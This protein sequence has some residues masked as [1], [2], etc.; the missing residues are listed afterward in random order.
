MRKDLYRAFFTQNPTLSDP[1]GAD[2]L[3]SDLTAFPVLLRVSVSVGNCEKRFMQGVFY[4]K[5]N[6][7]PNGIP[8]GQIQWVLTGF[9][10]YLN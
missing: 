2:R 5:L 8:S 4:T 3:K 6:A 1:V 9:N 7:V 10:R